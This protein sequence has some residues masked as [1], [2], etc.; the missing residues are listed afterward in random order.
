MI[1]LSDW[2]RARASSPPD[3]LE[4]RMGKDIIGQFRVASGESLSEFAAV[5]GFV[6]WQVRMSVA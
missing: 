3:V 4:G 2:L 5:D 6:P 1:I